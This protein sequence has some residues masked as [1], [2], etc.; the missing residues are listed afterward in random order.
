[1][2]IRKSQSMLRAGSLWEARDVLLSSDITAALGFT[3]VNKAGDVMARDNW[4]LLVSSSPA[5]VSCWRSAKCSIGSDFK[6][7]VLRCWTRLV[8]LNLW[9][10][11]CGITN[12]NG[13]SA[14]TQ[15]FVLGTAGTDIGI[16]SAG[17]AHTFDIPTASSTKRGAL[18]SADWSTFNS[19]MSNSW[20]PPMSGLV[21]RA[22]WRTAVSLWRFFDHKCRCGYC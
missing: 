21:T 13:L 16:S 12:M 19:K 5:A 10:L 11:R 17:S 14:G 4:S 8:L 20:R 15:S 1:M 18:S 6:T 22:C 2:S 9:A 3:P 7:N